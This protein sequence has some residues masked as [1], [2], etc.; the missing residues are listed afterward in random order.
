[1]KNH[2]RFIALIM[3]LLMF[4]VALAACKGEAEDL[5]AL[6]CSS[7]GRLDNVEARELD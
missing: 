6:K 3:A 1:M 2:L 7:T 4:T 5:A